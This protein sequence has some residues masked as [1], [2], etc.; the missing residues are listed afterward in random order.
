M[1]LAESRSQVRALHQHQQEGLL[2]L[3]QAWLRLEARDQLRVQ[4]LLG[5]AVQILQVLEFQGQ[6]VLQRLLELVLSY[7]VVRLGS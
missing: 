7:P 6:E 1:G 4:K 3:E 5:L 2:L